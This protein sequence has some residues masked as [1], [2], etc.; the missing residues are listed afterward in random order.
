MTGD[1]L[2]A[3]LLTGTT[4]VCRAWAIQRNDGLVIGFTDHDEALEFE[5]I[6]FSA[7]SGL[8]S[9][10]TEQTSGLAVDNSE[11]VGVLSDPAIQESDIRAG[12]FDGANVKSWL[13]NWQNFDERRLVFNGSLGEIERNGAEFR[14]ELRGLAES[15]ARVQ[16]RVYQ[17]N[18]GAVL[19]DTACGIDLS[20]P[21][22]FVDLEIMSVEHGVKIAVPMQPSF[23]E[24]WFT[25][26]SVEVLTG[27]SAGAI[28]AIK[29]DVEVGSS[30]TVEVWEYLGAGISPGDL[31]RLFAGC[32]KRVD[33][34]QI[35]FQNFVNF[36]GFPDIP[37]EDW[38][39][40]YP[41]QTGVNDGGSRRS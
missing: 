30:R 16:G 41:T 1:P 15:L 10:A 13:V 26:G 31:I 21:A 2:A 17:R 39:V 11:A 35:K 6:T 28:G 25:R 22:Y 40:S 37:G 3:H 12:K 33:T 23:A 14:A 24:G 38:L 34:C 5:G 18:C 9:S 29:R 4:T 27:A 32:D 20:D 7:S 19:G 8:S 36:Q